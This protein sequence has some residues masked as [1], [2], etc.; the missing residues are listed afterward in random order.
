MEVV[1]Y[2]YF[3]PLVDICCIEYYNNSS[4]TIPVIVFENNYLSG[5]MMI[6]AISGSKIDCSI[7]S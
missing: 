4:C 7:E 6:L 3:L 2:S 1:W 5:I